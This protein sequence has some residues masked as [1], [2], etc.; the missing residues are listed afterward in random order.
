MKKI[1]L[2]LLSVFT[3]ALLFAQAEVGGQFW[4]GTTWFL[5]NNV[6]D[7]G[8]GLDYRTSFGFSGGVN[9]AYYFSPVAGAG[10]E[11]NYGSFS[12]KYDGDPNANIHFTAQD[13]FGY[14]TIPILFKLRTSGGFYLDIGP[15]V[16]LLMSGNGTFTVDPDS[17]GTLSYSDREIKIGMSNVVFGGTFGF[18]GRFAL[19]ENMA[20]TA[21]L[22][23]AGSLADV[24]EELTETEF[25]QDVADEVLGVGSYYAHT[26]QSGDF[27]YQK[28]TAATGGIRI[29]FVYTFVE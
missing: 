9:A 22:H 27:F 25:A 11:V 8:Q 10:L 17:T 20:I 4:T 5:N 21:G 26:D 3:P 2:V 28:T 13:K 7:Q 19:N 14:V 15:Q 12:Q 24:T 23:F 18:G 6:S 1:T 16:N 29:G